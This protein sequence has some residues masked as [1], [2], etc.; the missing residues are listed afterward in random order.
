MFCQAYTEIREKGHYTDNDHWN[1]I[2]NLLYDSGLSK[3]DTWNGCVS[4]VT[5]GSD[6]SPICEGIF[7]LVGA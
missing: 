6:T 7:T 5:T 1:Y 2:S 3:S 4:H